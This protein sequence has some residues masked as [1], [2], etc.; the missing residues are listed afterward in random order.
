MIPETMEN[1][2]KTGISIIVIVILAALIVNINKIVPGRQQMAAEQKT[3]VLNEGLSY[4]SCF[5]EDQGTVVFVHSNS[6]PHCRTMMP[7]VEEL[8]NEGYKF[9]WAEGSDSEARSVIEG[10][11]SD[12]VSGYVPQFIC[13]ASGT[14]QTG[15]MSK[16][17]LKKF[18]EECTQ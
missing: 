2:W 7:I 12:L 3:A 18:A 17:D 6:C 15:A 4:D 13:P 1:I 10:C 14:E 8:E 5:S 11:F 9:Y 16:G